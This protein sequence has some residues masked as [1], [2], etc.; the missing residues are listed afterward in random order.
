[1][2]LWLDSVSVSVPGVTLT[3]SCILIYSR[4]DPINT[5]LLTGAKE[6]SGGN[7]HPP[8]GP[9]IFPNTSALIHRWEYCCPRPFG[10]LHTRSIC[11]L[12]LKTLPNQPLHWGFHCH[13]AESLCWQ[14]TV[15]VVS[16]WRNLTWN[17][18]KHSKD[19]F[20]L[21]DAETVLQNMTK[22]LFF[23]FFK[24]VFKL[25]TLKS[26]KLSCSGNIK[27]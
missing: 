17:E 18:L 22:K 25:D 8:M 9:G 14:W 26:S 2:R 21:L 5:W 20:F 4:L 13:E 12:N 10:K 6:K 23:L 16:K 15:M 19:V 24:D 7:E 27:C 3:F 1:M 11:W